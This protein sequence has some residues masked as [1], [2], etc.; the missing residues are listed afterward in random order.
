MQEK[1]FWVWVFGDIEGLR[2]VVRRNE[3]AFPDHTG[4]VAAKIQKGDQAILYVS[5]GAFRN[6]TKDQAR[7][8]GMVRVTSA[9]A[10]HREIT[11]GKKKYSWLVTFKPDTILKERT[12]PAVRSIIRKLS[13]V[14]RP[15]V[16]G[17]YFRKSPVAINVRD[18]RV[19]ARAIEVWN[20]RR[21]H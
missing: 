3:M 13:M 17:V 15:E 8:A 9:R 12:G 11:I 1:R 7:L 6:P 18:F 4:T 20:R 10:Q 21:F 5:R 2:W 19:M 14:R 16:W